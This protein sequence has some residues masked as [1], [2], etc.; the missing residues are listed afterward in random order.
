M[1]EVN[2]ESM[3][4]KNESFSCQDK[5]ISSFFEKMTLELEDKLQY[6]IKNKLIELGY[7]FKNDKE[8]F[9]FC[10]DRIRRICFEDHPNYYEFYL[11]YIN[12]QNR[13]TLIVTYS[14]EINFTDTGCNITSKIQ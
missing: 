2:I 14:S 10:K 9:E 12:P 8:F 13:G 4:S 1:N 3:F 5:V 11:D 7:E 6:Y